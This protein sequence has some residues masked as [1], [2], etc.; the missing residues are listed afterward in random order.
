M[1][2]ETS[3]SLSS[4]SFPSLCLSFHSSS[5]LFP[6]LQTWEH[7]KPPTTASNSGQSPAAKGI[8]VHFED[9]NNTF[10]GIKTYKILLIEAERRT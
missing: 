10:H 3:I 9:K 8:L 1:G 2:F 5:Y 4:L 6:F 7:Q